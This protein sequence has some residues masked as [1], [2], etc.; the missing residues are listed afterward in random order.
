MEA[1]W[2]TIFMLIILSEW[3]CKV[4]AA[5]C[6]SES[7]ACRKEF[8]E[9]QKDKRRYH[10]TSDNATLSEMCRKQLTVVNCVNSFA[11][12]C[13]PQE[14]QEHFKLLSLGSDKF[15]EQ[16]CLK[17]S[18]LRK[19]YLKH[20]TCIRKVSTEL[21]KCSKKYETSQKKLDAEEGDILSLKRK[22]CC[23]YFENINC[24]TK[25]TE[26]ICGQEAA[27]L[28][29]E[30]WTLLSGTF[31]NEICQPFLEYDHQTCIL[32]SRGSLVLPDWNSSVIYFLVLYCHFYFHKL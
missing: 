24:S 10:Y 21:D 16:F 28:V 13:L 6:E 8:D 29:E 12:E 9:L 31:L 30:L 22:T 20:S 14:Q 15:L 7:V 23:I 1:Y 4:F 3:Q 26:M 18:E 11:K 17:D 25:A 5:N 27:Q 32:L 19:R 2:I